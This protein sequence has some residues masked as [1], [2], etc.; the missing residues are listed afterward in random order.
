[1]IANAL[2]MILIA[3]GVHAGRYSS[4]IPTAQWSGARWTGR[5]DGARSHA[6]RQSSLTSASVASE[7]LR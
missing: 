3:F 4:A 2:A 6:Q 1:M 5:G 7:E